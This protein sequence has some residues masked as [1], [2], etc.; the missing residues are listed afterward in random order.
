MCVTFAHMKRTY[1][2]II[3]IAMG[4]S[5]VVLLVLQSRYA[6]AMVR[7]RK[8]QFDE[9]VFRSLD[10]ASRDLE[11]IETF[12]YLQDVMDEHEELSRFDLSMLLTEDSL[13]F[14]VADTV[15]Q[16]NAQQLMGLRMP[17]V[18]HM[19]QA[20]TNLQKHV[21]Q[22]YAY[23][24]EV[25]DEVVYAV[26]YRA[27][28]LSLQERLSAAQLDNSIRMALEANGI[29][30]PFHFVLYSADGAEVCRCMDYEPRGEEYVYTQMLFRSD[31]T[32]RMGYVQV[33]F[34]DQ[35]EFVMGAVNLVFPAMIFT[36]VLFITF[37]VTVYL[38]V[39][40]KRITEMKNDFIHNMTHEFK[41]PLSTIS[42]AAQMMS[43]KSLAK[44]DETYER[45]GG[46]IT[47]ETQRLRF[48]VEKVLQ[49]SLIEKGGVA[50]K[51]QELDANELI[52]G[53]VQTFSL[54]VSQ[55]GGTLE[56]RLEA[57][58]PFI[59]AD[60]MHFT[61]V[62][63]NLLDNAVKYKREDEPLRIEVRTWNEN[64]HLCI[65]IS[66]NGIG[67]QK[68]SLKRIFDRFY[69]VHTGNTHNVKGF[70]LGLAYVQSMVQMHH[71]TI[72]VQSELGKGTTFVISL[73]SNEE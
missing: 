42:I 36:V 71:G 47:N 21:Q 28:T 72:K 44:S 3:C 2:W 33:H 45:L 6:G 69:R 67:I 7:M 68:D 13:D 27:S 15:L 17:Q 55:N 5:F 62:I 49:M 46:V 48:Q 19:Q 38:V 32:G 4:F 50:L 63:F 70:G 57:I 73:M 22:A 66:D 29:T 65:S 18:D 30:L 39:R 52:D 12:R 1:I 37:M 56:Q 58:N 11:R 8:E 16:S 34:P 23:E 31:P 61:N 53:V 35:R 64:Q 14:D 40:Q 54:K 25:L 43:D 20:A 10:Q 26:M 9:N 41:T 51:L 59:D 24:R 60:E